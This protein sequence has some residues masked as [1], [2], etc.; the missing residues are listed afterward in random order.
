MYRTRKFYT[1]NIYSYYN[2]P[3]EEFK[4]NSFDFNL[5]NNKNNT[6]FTYRYNCVSFEFFI[7]IFSP[8]DK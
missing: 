8:T 6:N 3:T 5:V 1:I 7:I 4:D 2:I